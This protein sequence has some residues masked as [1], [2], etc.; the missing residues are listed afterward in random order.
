[1]DIN[2]NKLALVTGGNRGIGLEIC[3]QL[4]AQGIQV[5]LTSRD[6]ARGQEAVEVLRGFDLPVTWLQLDV[7]D[8]ASIS[9]L[10]KNILEKYGRLDV[11]VNNAAVSIDDRPGL[12]ALDFD[13]LRQ[14]ISDALPIPR[15]NEYVP[16]Q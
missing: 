2:K 6:E 9:S 5:I 14:S 10:H 1:M 8:P 3:R 13:I 4:G 16:V 15:R 12:L 11:L 7:T